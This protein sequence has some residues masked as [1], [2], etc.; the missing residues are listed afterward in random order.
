MK[1]FLSYNF[2]IQTWQTLRSFGEFSGA[3]IILPHI[4]NDCNPNTS[5][6]IRFH[7][8][9]WNSEGNNSRGGER[10]RGRE[11]HSRWWQWAAKQVLTNVS[12]SCLF[13]RLI[14][15]LCCSV[16]LSMYFGK[17]FTEPHSRSNKTVQIQNPSNQVRIS[18][19]DSIRLAEEP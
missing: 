6:G 14:M 12:S 5:V 17:H 18:G 3:W 2:E 7:S 19:S 13:P 1:M 11:Q 4:L 15:Y 8:S 9:S 10:W 16:S